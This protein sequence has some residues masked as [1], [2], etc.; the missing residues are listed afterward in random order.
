MRDIRAQLDNP[1]NSLVPA[2]MG[3]LDFGD[4]V[5]IWTGCGASSGV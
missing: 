5:A 3:R 1:P 2:D 4:W